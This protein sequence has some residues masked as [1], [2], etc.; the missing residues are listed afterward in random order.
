M[1]LQAALVEDPAYSQVG[2][3]VYARVTSADRDLDP[4]L[5]CVDAQGKVNLQNPCTRVKCT[6]AP[7]AA[8]ARW[9]AALCLLLYAYFYAMDP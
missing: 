1:T 6:A 7:R 8:L 4:V 2:D 3:I 9:P 5:A